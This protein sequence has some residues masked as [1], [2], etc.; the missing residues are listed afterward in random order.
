MTDTKLYLGD[1]LEVMKQ[2]PDGSVDMV[3]GDLPFGTTRNGWD[4]IIPFESLWEQYHRIVK[5][6]GA[7]LQFSQNPFS[8]ELIMSNKNEFRYE[9][10]WEKTSGTGWLN[11]HKMP[12]KC[13]ENILV[14]YKEL[15]VYNPQ[16]T[17]GEPYSKG[18][19]GCTSNYNKMKD[20]EYREYGSKRFPRDVIKF[21]NS[22]RHD[23]IHPTQKP[24]DILSYL[25]LTY[26]NEGDTVLDNCMGSGSTGVACIETGRNFIGIEQDE[27]YFN[28]SKDRI[29]RRKQ[30]GVQGELFG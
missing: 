3:C 16:F 17:Y 23:I 19:I 14:F 30:Q 7:I 21:N 1:C 15:P 13:H 10:I 5:P 27:H 11:S 24:V 28:V 2:I 25:I 20:F 4:V 22:D 29:E 6:S 9:W 26:T 8:A 18:S 12:L